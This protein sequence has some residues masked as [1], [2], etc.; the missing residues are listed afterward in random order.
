MGPSHDCGRQHQEVPGSLSIVGALEY[1]TDCSRMV[2]YPCEM[3]EPYYWCP[4]KLCTDEA[5]MVKEGD[6]ITQA[7]RLANQASSVLPR[8]MVIGYARHGKDTTCEYLRDRYGFTFVSSSNFVLEKAVRPRLAQEGYTYTSIEECQAQRETV[9][10]WRRIWFEAIRDYNTPDP[11]R[12][13]KEL[14]AQYDIYCGIRRL[15]EFLSLQ[16]AKVF[17]VAIWIDASVRLPPEADTSNTL[18]PNIVDYVVS[19]NTTLSD[20]H[21]RLDGIM[22][23]LLPHPI[24]ITEY[25]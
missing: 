10:D 23:G 16:A 5:S 20:L 13:G 24:T 12:L 2:E 25:K 18:S 15:E 9:P 19:N 6:G 11:A 4:H 3:L 17:D 1:C 21:R 8:L 14:Y 7:G 22:Q